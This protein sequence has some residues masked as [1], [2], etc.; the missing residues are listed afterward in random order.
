MDNF[1]VPLKFSRKTQSKNRE[2]YALPQKQKLIILLTF[3]CLVG[4][5]CHVK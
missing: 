5:V 4:L 2:N 1:F 3:D